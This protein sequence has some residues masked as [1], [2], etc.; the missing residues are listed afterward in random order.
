[1]FLKCQGDHQFLVL[2]TPQF[3]ACRNTGLLFPHG[4]YYTHISTAPCVTTRLLHQQPPPQPLPL[5]L[6]HTQ[7]HLLVSVSVSMIAEVSY[8]LQEHSDELRQPVV[9]IDGH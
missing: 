6:P 7:T 8:H 2:S 3:P 1:M 9:I 4:L 5:Q